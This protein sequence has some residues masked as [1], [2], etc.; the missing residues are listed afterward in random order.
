MIKRIKALGP[1][2]ASLSGFCKNRYV[3]LNPGYKGIYH[4]RNHFRRLCPKA[5]DGYFM[6]FSGSKTM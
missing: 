4:L 3:I 1:V 5:A 2:I 6:L